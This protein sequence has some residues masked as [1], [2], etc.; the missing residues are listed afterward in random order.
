[1]DVRERGAAAPAAWSCFTRT[2]DTLLDHT[3]GDVLGTRY[4]YDSHVVNH[5]SISPGDLVVLRDGQLILGHGV[6]EAVV[7][8][9]GVKVMRRCPSCDS[10]RTTARKHALP[11]YRCNGCKATFDEPRMA[12]TDVTRYTATYARTWTPLNSPL[13]V[14][15]LDTVYAGADQQNAIRRLDRTRALDMLG[16]YGGV[17]GALE[18]AV[19][20]HGAPVTGGHVDAVVRRRVGQQRFRERLLDRYGATCAVTGAQP[21]MV[22]DAAHLYRFA[23]RPEHL[24]DG[25]LLLRADV[26]RLFDRL[27][28]TFNPKTWTTQVAP[29]LLERHE[30]LAALDGRRIWVHESL[31]PDVELIEEHHVAAR[32]RWKDLARV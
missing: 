15:A 30:S 22:L 18:A 11:R 13:P 4:E 24:D 19:L 6:V 3:Y 5:R 7:S 28:L 12:P 16:A 8:S 21:E 10:A 27:V 17:E 26:H 2:S 1:M 9:P 31:L 20:R 14:R 32:A 25:G 23:D 29:R